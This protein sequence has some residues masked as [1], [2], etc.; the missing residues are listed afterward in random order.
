M[1]IIKTRIIYKDIAWFLLLDYI[2]IDIKKVTNQK[3]KKDS[4]IKIKLYLLVVE[5]IFGFNV[6]TFGL[7]LGLIF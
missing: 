2:D 6:I 3:T 4:K 5:N 1:Q 7:S